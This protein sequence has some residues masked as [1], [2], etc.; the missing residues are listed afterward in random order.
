MYA[1]FVNKKIAEYYRA[2]HH[3]DIVPH[4]PPIE[5]FGYLHSC[6]EVFEDI[7][8]NLNICSEADCEDSKCADQ[9]KLTETNTDDHIYYLGHRLSCEESTI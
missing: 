2:T 4:V 1:K 7:N 9:Y 8:G 6:R 5:G 3:K